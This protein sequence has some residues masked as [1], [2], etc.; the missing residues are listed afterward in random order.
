V[1]R[2]QLDMTEQPEAA[3]LRESSKVVCAAGH[4]PRVG[5]AARIV[6]ARAP[7]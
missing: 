5:S 2:M 6:D 4:V 1:A 7:D 3:R